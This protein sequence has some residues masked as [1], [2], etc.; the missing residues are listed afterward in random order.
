MKYIITIG[1]EYGSGGKEIGSRLAQR[2][3]IPFYDKELLAVAA[4]E[5]GI[6]ENLFYENDESQQ[7]SFIYSLMMGTYAL[8]EGG[9]IYPELPLN[10][11]IFIAQFEAIKKIAAQGPCVLVGR[12]ADYVLRDKKNIINIFICGDMEC[13]K[14]RVA[15]RLNISPEKAEEKIKKTDK[16]RSNY[17]N[18]NTESRWG[19]ASNYDLCINSS[20]VGI[21]K[22]VDLI[23]NYINSKE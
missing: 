17:Y 9:R 15:K 1:R 5:S 2:L 16:K 11:K 7:G 14:N 19:K 23:E 21:E 12:C 18:Y 13:K 10:H 4:K 8:G 20:K 22:A 3:D 6:A